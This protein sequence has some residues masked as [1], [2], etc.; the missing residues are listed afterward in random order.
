MWPGA[1]GVTKILRDGSLKSGCSETLDPKNWDEI[2]ARSS[3]LI[4]TRRAL[5]K[6][7]AGGA[8]A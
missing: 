1:G 2:R 3:L 8:P 4:D 6:S 5:A 7:Q